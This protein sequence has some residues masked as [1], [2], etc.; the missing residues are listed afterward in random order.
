MQPKTLQSNPVGWC[1]FALKVEPSE[2]HALK[3]VTLCNDGLTLIKPLLS[4]AV[5]LRPCSAT[6]LQATG[7]TAYMFAVCLTA[8][9]C[10]VYLQTGIDIISVAARQDNAVCRGAF[11]AQ[12]MSRL[13]QIFLHDVTLALHDKALTELGIYST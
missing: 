2:L 1:L 11:A 9:A 3:T 4:N 5:V 13:H 6:S 7:M 12:H 10:I 8:F